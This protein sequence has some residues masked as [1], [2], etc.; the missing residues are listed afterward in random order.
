MVVLGRRT[1]VLQRLVQLVQ[2]VPVFARRA[3]RVEYV[4]SKLGLAGDTVSCNEL[5]IVWG[6]WTGWL[7]HGPIVGESVVPI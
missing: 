2:V 6:A 5:R 4:V 1:E 7:A 3:P